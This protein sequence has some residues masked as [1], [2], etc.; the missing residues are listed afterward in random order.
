MGA[1][2]AVSNIGTVLDVCLTAPA[3]FDQAGYEGIAAGDWKTVG[4]ITR[5]GERGDEAEDLPIGT[6]EDGRVIHFNGQ[7]DGGSY[8]V[9][10]IITKGDE[11]QELVKANS[12][13]NT[14]IYF[15]ETIPNGD[16]IYYYGL[17]SGFRLN[18]AT[19]SS[20]YGATFNVRRNSAAVEVIAP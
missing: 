4:T 2:S 9:T 19:T 6:L 3:T 7:V 16:V 17:A 14:T 12:A 10:T 1:E 15:R 5:I 8:P 20:F 18:E 13:G 11:G